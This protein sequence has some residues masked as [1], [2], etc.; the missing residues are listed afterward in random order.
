MTISL[1]SQHAWKLSHEVLSAL[2]GVKGWD[3]STRQIAKLLQSYIA[4]LLETLRRPAVIQ[5]IFIRAAILVMDTLYHTKY[6]GRKHDE[7]DERMFLILPTVK[8]SI[9]LSDFSAVLVVASEFL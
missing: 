9:F 1:T 2:A 8:G 5:R 4:L 7:S 3:Q 6:V